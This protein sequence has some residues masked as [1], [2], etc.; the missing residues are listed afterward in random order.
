MFLLTNN[1]DENQISPIVFGKMFS[2]LRYFIW[3]STK[4]IFLKY[5]EKSPKFAFSHWES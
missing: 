3:K 4:L 2:K 1:L 5:G